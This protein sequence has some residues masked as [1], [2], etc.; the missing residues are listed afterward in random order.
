MNAFFTVIATDTKMF[1][2]HSLG[3]SQF[4]PVYECRIEKLN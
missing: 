4:F 3:Q 2:I 1:S